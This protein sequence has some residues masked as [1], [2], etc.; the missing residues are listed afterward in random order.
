M[1]K[2]W[3]QLQEKNLFNISLDTTYHNDLLIIIS[4]CLILL[5]LNNKNNTL[6]YNKKYMNL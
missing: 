1:R 2:I 5:T 3:I 4:T 6:N